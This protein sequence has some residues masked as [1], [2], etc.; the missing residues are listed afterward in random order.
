[1]DNVCLSDKTGKMQN[2]KCFFSR[3]PDPIGYIG[4]CVKAT[5]EQN[6]ETWKVVDCTDVTT[7]GYICQRRQNFGE[8]GNK[9]CWGILRTNESKALI[10]A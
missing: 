9:N 1:M 5:F 8:I 3:N 6:D 4:Q 7:K 2:L 10:S